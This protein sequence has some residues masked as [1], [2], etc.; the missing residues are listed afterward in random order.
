M[1]TYHRDK[2]FE[3]ANRRV[4]CSVC[5]R[6]GSMYSMLLD[7]SDPAVLTFVHP[8]CASEARVSMTLESDGSYTRTPHAL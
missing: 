1:K 7:V 6:H 2:S 8:S 4:E 5:E 3:A